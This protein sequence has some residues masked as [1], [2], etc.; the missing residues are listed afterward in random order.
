MCILLSV[1]SGL[2]LTFW[3]FSYLSSI[4]REWADVG[5]MTLL[6]IMLWFPCIGP[7]CCPA[8]SIKDWLSY[9]GA[10]AWDAFNLCKLWC[11]LY[12]SHWEL[13]SSGERNPLSDSYCKLFSIKLDRL[14]C[15][16]LAKRCGLVSPMLLKRSIRELRRFSWLIKLFF[17]FMM[18]CWAS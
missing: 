1:S 9:P 5:L 8:A 2:I 12:E 14:F 15:L 18:R 11:W 16:R 13:P 17:D 6:F 4:G 7:R 10:G 3:F